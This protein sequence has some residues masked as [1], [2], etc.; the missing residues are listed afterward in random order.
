MTENVEPAAD[1][2]ARN[3]RWNFTVNL[4]EM[5]F[6]GLGLNMISQSTILPLLIRSLTPSTIAVGLLSSIFSLG[7]L[8]PQLLTAAYAEGLRRKKKFVVFYSGLG[9]RV[10]YLLIG[11]VVWLFAVKAPALTLAAIYLLILIAATTAGLLTP[12]WLD[13]IAKVIPAERRG[14]FFGLGGG[15]SSLMGVA[16]A[17]LSGWFLSRWPY[18]QNFALC[19]LAAGVCLA[20]SFGGIALTR[21]PDSETVKEHGSLKEYFQKLPAIL[22]RD[23]NYQVFL[24]GR[25]LVGLGGMAAGFFIIYGAERFG[26]SG[27]SVGGLTAV[28]VGSQA[29]FNLAWGLLAD[30]RGHK[31]VLVWSALIMGAAALTAIAAHAAALIWLVFAL[32]GVSAAGDNVSGFNILLEFCPDDE[33]PTY[34]GLTNTLLA[35]FRALAPLAGGA[36]AAW[37]GYQ[38]MFAFAAGFAL[39]GSLLL[40]LWLREP[41]RRGK[42]L[43]V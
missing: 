39:L 12:A 13:L 36:L 19:F 6:F 40:A 21:E 18:P 11:V 26:V 25:A 29:V 7:F 22:R 2:V 15:S 27:E 23:R 33:R 1:F 16:G 8:L 9:E 34:V 20:V 38:A 10:P 37:L 4:I 42:R 35:P 43:G 32:V 5:A 30:R 17:G 28:L 3:F 14:R 24:A 31:I 41:R